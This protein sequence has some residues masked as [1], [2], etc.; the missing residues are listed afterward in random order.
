MNIFSNQRDA[1]RLWISSLTDRELEH[2]ENDIRLQMW[3]RRDK[4]KTSADHFEK[5]MNINF[6]EG[7]A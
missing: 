1:F 7:G 2:I 4:P 6:N 3:Y 5:I